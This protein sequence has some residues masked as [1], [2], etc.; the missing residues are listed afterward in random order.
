M[1]MKK[2]WF[3]TIVLSLVLASLACT[4]QGAALAP[5]PLTTEPAN[6]AV[7]PPTAAVAPGPQLVGEGDLVEL[8]TQVSGGVVSIRVYN[9]SGGGQGSG[10]VYD[11]EGHIVTNGHVVADAQQI[12]V[13]FPSGDKV[14]AELVGV[15]TNVDLAVVRADV[16]ASVLHPLPLGDSSQVRVGEIVVAIGNPFGLAGT[17]TV[18]VVS[19]LGRTL[20]SER[21]APGGGVFSSGDIIQTDAAINLGNSGGPLVDLRGEVVGVNRAILTEAFSVVGA[22]TNSGVGFAIP[23]NLARRVVEAILAGGEF[24]YPY[25]GVLCLS[26]LDLQTVEALGLTRVTG[27]YV[28]EVTPGGPA[29][30]AGVVGGA[31]PA[32]IGDV[33]RGGD[34]IVAIEG[35][36]VREF[37]DLLSYLVNYTEPGQVVS[38]T[39]VRNGEEVEVPV[40]IGARP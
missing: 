2:G 39:V 30:R 32:V 34:L 4:W 33:P 8:Y 27:A 15:D 6:S 12:E 28:Q 25:L 23:V 20:D 1:M 18:G 5:T 24:Q 38:L 35:S 36:P 26:S 10:F 13:D 22:P 16:P 31:G 7:A 9:E 40:T 29:D 21:A 3:P 19:A 11:T 17:M 37:A 14:W